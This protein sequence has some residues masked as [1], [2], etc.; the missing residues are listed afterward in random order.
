MCVDKQNAATLFVQKP[1]K[2]QPSAAKPQL[3]KFAPPDSDSDSDS[4]AE[5]TKVSG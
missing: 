1:Q 3:A 4:E 5:E 2:N